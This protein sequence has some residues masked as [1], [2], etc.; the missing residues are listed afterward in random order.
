M[1]SVLCVTTSDTYFGAMVETMPMPMN[2]IAMMQIAISQCSRRC[3][4]VKRGAGAAH[5]WVPSFAAS[6][7]G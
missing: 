1:P 7:R 6:L 3:R 2:S 4:K 5:G